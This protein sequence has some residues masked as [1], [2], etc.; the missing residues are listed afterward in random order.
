MNAESASSQGSVRQRV[1]DV[2]ARIRPAVQD[3]GGD[4]EL[5]EITD[6]GEVRVRFHG[7]C[8]HC[9]SSSM[10]LQHG[11]EA[12]LK[13]NVPEVTSVTAVP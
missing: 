3:D 7:D 11:I 6:G 8:V 10:T 1:E 2:L 9:P 13:A 12:N 4:I 5:V